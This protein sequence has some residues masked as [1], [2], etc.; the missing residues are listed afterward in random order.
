MARHEL[1]REGVG[2]G[3]VGARVPG[4]GLVLPLLVEPE[5]VGDLLRG[6]VDEARL[7]VEGH[8][9][10]VVA[11]EGRRPHLDGLRRD[12]RGRASRSGGRSRGRCAWP[13]SPS[14]R[15]PRRAARPSRD[16]ARRRS[17][18]SA[19]ASAPC[20]RGRRSRARPGSCAASRCSPSCRRAWSG[21]ARPARRYRAAAPGSTRGRGCRRRRGCARSGS[22]A[23]RCRCRRRA[24]RA[25]GRRRASPRPCRRRRPSTT[26]RSRSRPPRASAGFSKGAP[27]FPGTV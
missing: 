5:E 23:S 11:A 10:P 7:R 1:A 17:R 15:D 24:D 2:D 18:S 3:R 13:R 21:S 6:D 25:R 27:G 22:R 14:R 16:R 9:L 19:P 26:R 12:S 4:A 8:R 20:A